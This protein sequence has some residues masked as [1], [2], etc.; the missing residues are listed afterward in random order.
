MLKIQRYFRR[1]QPLSCLLLSVL[2]GVLS[3][4]PAALPPFVEARLP[5]LMPAAIAASNNPNLS[6]VMKF[7]EAYNDRS[8]IGLLDEIFAADYIGFVNGRKIPDVKASRS[9]ITAFLDAFPDANYVIEDTIIAGDR[10]VTRWDCTATHRGKFL[11]IE[12]TNQPIEITGITI[13]KLVNGKIVRLWNNWDTFG[14][15][16]QLRSAG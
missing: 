2:V 3:L 16:Q 6:T 10:I 5:D 13:F 11:G 14:L 8:K 12:P 4:A 7:Y 9:F 1:W 15:M